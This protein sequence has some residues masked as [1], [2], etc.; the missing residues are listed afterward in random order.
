MRGK[1]FLTLIIVLAFA[2]SFVAQWLLTRNGNELDSDKITGPERIVSMS[3]S[4]TEALFELGLGDRTVGVTTF[5]RYP[6][7]AEKIDKVGGYLDPNYEAIVALKPDLVILRKEFE[8]AEEKL[9]GLGIRTLI[10]DHNNIDGIIESFIRIGRSCGA[11]TRAKQ[12]V[13]DLKTRMNSLRE[14]TSGQLRPKVLICIEREMGTGSIRRVCAVG[15]DGFYNEMIRIAGGTCVF[16]E[17]GIA[18]PKV[19]IEGILRADPDII[20]DIAPNLAGLN[21]DEDTVLKD[22]QMISEVAAVKNNRLHVMTQDF[23][24]I[25]GPRFIIIIEELAKIIHPELE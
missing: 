5:C 4:V 19:S 6:P 24:V 11:G 7:E 20:I 23:M 16:E 1:I 13:A 12:I 21:L 9:E 3:P 8:E 14:K 10:V 18:F 22:W 17:T 15:K 2:G 25:P